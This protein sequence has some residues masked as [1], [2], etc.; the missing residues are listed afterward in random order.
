MSGRVKNSKLGWTKRRRVVTCI[1]VG[2]S[3]IVFGVL[4]NQFRTQG[5]DPAALLDNAKSKVL[6]RSDSL[7]FQP[8]SPKKLGLIFLCGSGVEAEAYAG[9]LRPIADNGYPTVIVRLPGRFAMLPG[10]KEQTLDVAETLMGQNPKVKHWVI[11]GHS[12]G[13]ALSCQFA[14]HRPQ[15]CSG[16]VLVATTHP[17]DIDL[18]ALTIPVTKIYG[19]NDG[20]APRAKVD[21]NRKLLPVATQWV[22]VEG[23]NHSQFGN[24]GHQLQDGSASISREAQQ[25][26]VKEKILDMLARLESGEKDLKVG[27]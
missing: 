16:L 12:L 11:S 21:A 5:V 9:M 13:A 2:W 20:V 24:Y 19:T 1:F 18:S 3:I 25:L 15:K 10:Q 22:L 27:N 7:Q 17:K 26:V 14:L 8:V 4:L 23:A 6:A